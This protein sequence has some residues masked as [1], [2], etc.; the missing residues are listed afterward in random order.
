MQVKKNPLSRVEAMKKARF[1]D[2]PVL[3]LSDKSFNITS[4]NA[5][6]GLVEQVNNMH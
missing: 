5:W 1:K 4:V 6:K 3:E 2:G